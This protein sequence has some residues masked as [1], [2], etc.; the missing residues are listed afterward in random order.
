MNLNRI[1]NT[2]KKNQFLFEELVIRDF[3]QKYKRTALGMLW[4]ILNPLLTL[5][6]MRLVFTNFFGRNTLYYTTYLFAGNLMFS[7]YK[8]QTS[9]GMNSLMMNAHIFT[10]INI[11][12]YMFLLSKSIS[13]IINFVL[14]LIVFFFFVAID[15]V[16]FHWTMFAIIYPILTLTMFN[17][18]VGMV[19][20][21]LYVFFRD[22]AY[23]YDIFTLLL[24]YMSAIFYKVDDFPIWIQRVFLINPVYCNIKYV[25]VAVIDGNLPSPAFHL[26]LLLYG[27]LALGLG[28]WVYKKYNHQFLYYV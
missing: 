18:G 16:P 9:G 2:L 3:K 5:L 4:S 19:L 7:Y 25:R 14:T 15:G 28:A 6:V 8:E 23:I 24:M 17:V 11:P 13:A 21:A 1:I 26:L 27:A 10:K 20:S 22:I 12:K